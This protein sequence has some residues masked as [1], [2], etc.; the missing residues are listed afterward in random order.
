MDSEN[1]LIE[2]HPVRSSGENRVVQP[3]GA[4]AT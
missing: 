4:V 3:I 2:A 1:V